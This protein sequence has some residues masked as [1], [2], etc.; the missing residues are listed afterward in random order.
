M[1]PGQKFA[2]PARSV[3]EMQFLFMNDMRARGPG[4]A[5]ALSNDTPVTARSRI[6]KNTSLSQE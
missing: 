4:V 6:K 2:N 1:C 3:R 5:S